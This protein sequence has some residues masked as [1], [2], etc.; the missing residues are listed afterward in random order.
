[1]VSHVCRHV[2]RGM[3]RRLWWRRCS[4]GIRRVGGRCWRMGR[5]SL[6]ISVPGCMCWGLRCCWVDRDRCTGRTPGT[7]PP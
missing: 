2:L 7:M 6:G 1:M 5:E 4:G 3:S